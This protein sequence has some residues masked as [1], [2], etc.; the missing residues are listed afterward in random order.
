MSALTLAA[1]DQLEQS[2]A[3]QA[4]PAPV[5]ENHEMY[6]VGT[7]LSVASAP[8]LLGEGELEEIIETPACTPIPG[9]KPWVLGVASHKGGL[10]PIICGDVLF[11]KTPYVGKTREYCMV[12]RRPGFHFAVTLSHIERDIRFPIASRD[13]EQA[14]DPDF[15]DYCLGGF[16][17]GDKF[18]AVLD[19]DKLVA[20]SGLANASATNRASNEES[21]DD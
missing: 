9:T 2:Y 5:F 20:E 11:R 19:I 1:F 3:S 10:I 4:V 12:V 16:H 18:L 6:W 8:L 17:Y 21:N 7:S 14:I 15:S 13:M